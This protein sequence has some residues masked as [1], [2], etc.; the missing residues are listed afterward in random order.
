MVTR[1]KLRQTTSTVWPGPSQT[2]P[3]VLPKRTNRHP[4]GTSSSE[5]VLPAAIPFTNTVAAVSEATQR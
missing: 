4:Q 2:G 1:V 3:G 5:F